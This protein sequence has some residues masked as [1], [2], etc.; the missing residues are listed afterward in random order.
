MG[1]EFLPNLYPWGLKSAHTLTLIE[2][3][4]YGLSSFGSPS[5]P[6]RLTHLVVLTL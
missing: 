4:P 5:T 2:E 6:L 3:F 1:E